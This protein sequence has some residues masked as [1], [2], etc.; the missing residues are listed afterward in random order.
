MHIF[1]CHL[2]DF[3]FCS[4]YNLTKRCQLV[5]VSIH[6]KLKTIVFFYIACVVEILLYFLYETL[7]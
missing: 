5:Q 3:I 2:M 6:I 4:M 1:V 7:L